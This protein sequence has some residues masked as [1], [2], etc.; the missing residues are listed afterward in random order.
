MN[1]RVTI[2]KKIGFALP[3]AFGGAILGASIA[4]APGAVI[5]FLVSLLWIV[6]FFTETWN[7]GTLLI[8][9]GHAELIVKACNEVASD[10]PELID[11]V[12]RIADPLRDL[13]GKDEEEKQK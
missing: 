13:L 11:E 1:K 2:L 5:G 10:H 9:R 7:P 6:L 3:L 12:N 4:G 8:T